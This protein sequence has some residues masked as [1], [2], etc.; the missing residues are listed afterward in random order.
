[1][2]EAISNEAEAD[3]LP[4]PASEVSQYTYGLHGVRVG[5]DNR[6]SEALYGTM[7]VLCAA[8]VLVRLAQR[9]R[10]HL[11]H[12]LSLTPNNDGQAYWQQ[13]WTS[14][15]PRL[16]RHLLYAPL[17]H[18]RH[19]REIQLSTAVNVGTLPSRLHTLVLLL[20]LA[21]NVAYLCI[22]D[23]SNSNKASL[24]A[25]LRGR[26]GHLATMNMMALVLFAGRNNPLIWLLRVSFDTFNLFHRWLGRIVVLEAVIHTIAW[27]VNERLAHGPD[28]I[29]AA[30]MKEP[31]LQVGV[32][33]TIAMVIIFFHSPSA[34]RHAFYE[35]FLI[36][37]QLLALVA[38]IAVYAHAKLGPLPQLPF[39][40]LV[41]LLWSYDRLFRLLRL[42]YRNLGW[43]KGC[44]SVLVEA[45]PGDACRVTF[46]LPRAWTPSP[47]AHVY[48]YLPAVS[49]WQSHPFSVAWSTAPTDPDPPR[50]LLPAASAG[51]AA[52]HLRASS[53]DAE[54]PD[55]TVTTTELAAPSG[56]SSATHHT[57][58][59]LTAA[60]TGMTRA[61]YARAAAAPTRRLHLRGALEGPYG[62]LESLRS[63]GTLV[64]FA[65]G[66]GITHLL[67]H[68]RDLLARA[69]PPARRTVAARRVLLVWTVRDATALAWVRP[70]MDQLL[71]MP[72]RRELLRV[73]IY[74]TR[75]KSGREVGSPSERVRMF[76]GRPRAAVIVRDEVRERVGGMCVGVC[77][78][79][80][81][82][83]DVRSA[84]RGVEGEGAVDFWE[85]AFTW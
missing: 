58:S 49:G 63:Y 79:G 2:P 71:A 80:A 78:P 26:S 11:R 12:L 40:I 77:G 69:H 75:P 37:H 56:P 36:L 5:L 8:A 23:Y 54:K 22:L 19:N 35:I 7:L 70:W 29:N 61:L 55:V 17:I 39:T 43:R 20:F 64:L 14:W 51:P 47:G 46:F 76:A 3:A 65:G 74:V 68:L 81:L 52:H 38:V 27:A 13:E 85:E 53:S 62:S 57:V 66:V 31:F 30:I 73:Q 15:W 28:G 48:A 4:L 6:T 72:G 82:A 33:G 41:I 9:W 44:T 10:A 67:P 16:K 83:D 25:E 34:I 45:L 60:R 24:T 84:V 32:A 21:S 42:A 59:L 50:P 18:K 1:M